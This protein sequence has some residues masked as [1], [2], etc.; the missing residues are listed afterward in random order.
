[1]LCYAI[2]VPYPSRW[3][4]LMQDITL[5]MCGVLAIL[6]LIAFLGWLLVLVLLTVLP[7]IYLLSVLQPEVRTIT[8]RLQ[9]EY[10]S[11]TWIAE[12]P[13]HNL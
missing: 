3:T 11:S 4:L 1:M 8:L 13:N 7:P 6:M 9:N 10:A 12:R 2:F 5:A